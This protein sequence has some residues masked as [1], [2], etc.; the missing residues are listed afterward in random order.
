MAWAPDSQS[1]FFAAPVAGTEQVFRIALDGT[2]ERVTSGRHDLNG[3]CVAPDGRTLYARKQTME[4]PYEIV[5]IDVDGGAITPVT[6]VNGAI[7]ATL[8]L[9]AV[10]ELQVRAVDG[11]FVHCW[12]IKPPGFDESNRYPLL[13]YCQGGPQSPITQWFSHRWNFHLMAAKGYVVVAPNRRGLPGFGQAWN[14]AISGDWGGLAMQDYLAA[15]DAMF[16][17]PWIDREH[18]AAIGASFGGY[19]VYWLMG[20]DQADRFCAMIAHCGLFN[21]ESWYGTTEELWF[22]NWDIGGPYW[23]GAELE[24]EYRENSPHRFVGEWDTPLLVIHG[25]KD[26]R[27]PIAEGMQAFTAAKLRGVPARF[28]YFPNEGHWVNGVQNGVLWNRVFFDW[29][30]RYCKPKE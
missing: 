14:D 15:T 30:D 5:R 9:P 11:A 22:A 1:L 20:H 6:D 13:T 18:T 27:V 3:V 26:F 17:K 16:E 7:Y 4:R 19:S 28:L 24:A 12:V 2:V 29:L 21:L 8:E 10:E 23:Q 25:E